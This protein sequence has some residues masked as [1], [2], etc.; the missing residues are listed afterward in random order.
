M[1][2]TA[3]YD[4]IYKNVPISTKQ[5][6][7]VRLMEVASRSES[8]KLELEIY[9][10]FR[11]K[12]PISPK[13]EITTDT[14]KQQR[15]PMKP[16][17]QGQVQ[18]QSQDKNEKHGILDTEWTL[19]FT[20]LL[21]LEADKKLVGEAGDEYGRSIA[22]NIDKLQKSDFE[23]MTCYNRIER[24]N[25]VTIKTDEIRKSIENEENHLHELFSKL[26]LAQSDLAKCLSQPAFF[27]AETKDIACDL[28]KGDDNFVVGDLNLAQEQVEEIATQT[29]AENEITSDN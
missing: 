4:F 1:S 7:I 24:L 11:L 13:I 26:K 29:K 9:I 3:S 28:I 17:D 6:S 22:K 12:R 5:E 15:L 10:R 14:R 16:S 25:K 23:R 18:A 8:N 19:K 27:K 21:K 2:K 20:E